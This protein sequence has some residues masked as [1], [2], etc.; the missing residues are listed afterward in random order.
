MP[1]LK[2][3]IGSGP[4]VRVALPS[5]APGDSDTFRGKSVVSCYSL[6]CS[7]EVEFPRSELQLFAKQVQQVHET[8]K[9]EFR[10]ESSDTRFRLDGRADNKGRIRIDVLVSGFQFSQPENNEWSASASFTC[11]PQELEG[12]ISELTKANKAQHPTA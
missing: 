7:S 10:L 6:Q 2:F 12:A 11:F 4:F 9:G 3:Q 5:K 8:L 1:T